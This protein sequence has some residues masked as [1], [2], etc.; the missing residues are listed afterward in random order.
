MEI[1]RY[2]AMSR[3]VDDRTWRRY[4]RRMQ[5]SKAGWV[6]GVG[7]LLAACGSPPPPETPKAPEP[8]PAP[9][10][11][12][13]AKPEP[14]AEEPP[15]QDTPEAPPAAET[16]KSTATIGGVSISEIDPKTLIAAVQKAGWAPEDVQINHGTV[17]KFES[18]EFGILKGTDKG[19]FELVRRAAKPTGSSGSMM[20]PK[21]QAKMREDRGAVFLDEQAEVVIMIVVDGKPAIAKKVLELVLKK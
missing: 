7:L 10:P 4:E 15:P 6:L 20:S 21:D 18:I 16:P 19:T 13:E 12:P 2:H 5:Q 11:A 1:I 8:A 14:K 17:G 9:P 3:E